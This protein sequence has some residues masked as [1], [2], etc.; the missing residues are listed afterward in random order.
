MTAKH[1]RVD[2]RRK[3]LYCSVLKD[4]FKSK[5]LSGPEFEDFLISLEKMH[6]ILSRSDWQELIFETAEPEKLE[7]HACK[8]QNVLLASGLDPL[9]AR[10]VAYHVRNGDADVIAESVRRMRLDILTITLTYPGYYEPDR[11]EVTRAIRVYYEKRDRRRLVRVE[12]DPTQSEVTN[13]WVQTGVSASFGELVD[14]ML[15]S[16]GQDLYF[17]DFFNRQRV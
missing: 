16:E 5:E 11:S 13:R 12:F 14:W 3:D 1:S 17:D 6:S 9:V 8:V 4:V 7:D 10:W 15:V 2:N